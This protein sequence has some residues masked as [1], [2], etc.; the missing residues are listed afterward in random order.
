M[1]AVIAEPSLLF[2]PTPCYLP[3]RVYDRKRV[4]IRSTVRNC[5]ALYGL[6]RKRRALTNWRWKGSWR[7]AAQPTRPKEKRC[8]RAETLTL[9]VLKVSAR[10]PGTFLKLLRLLR[11]A[12]AATLE[13]CSRPSSMKETYRQREGL[14]LARDGKV[15]WFSLRHHQ[16]SSSN[17]QPKILDLGRGSLMSMSA[18]KGESQPCL[19]LPPSLHFKARN[20]HRERSKNNG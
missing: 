14:S 2:S 8:H 10:L 4:V 19:K 18:R 5:T 1:N 20:G 9:Q 6:V 16:G 11:L 13:H 12:R 7:L 17:L 15:M 3:A